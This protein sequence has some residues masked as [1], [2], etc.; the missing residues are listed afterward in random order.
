MLCWETPQFLHHVE[1]PDHVGLVLGHDLLGREGAVVFTIAKTLGVEALHLPATGHVP[2]PVTL[3]ERRTAD[4]L[5]RPV[6]NTARGELFARVLPEEGAVVHVEGQKAAQIGGGRIP[7]EPA[8]AVVCAHENPAPRHHGIAIRLAAESG[9]PGDVLARLGLPDSRVKVEFAGRPLD[10][11]IPR[12]GHVVSLG[13]A[14]PLVPVGRYGRG[15][16][17]GRRQDQGHDKGQ[18]KGRETGTAVHGRASTETVSMKIS[19]SLAF[20]KKPGLPCRLPAA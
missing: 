2:E 7:L 19:E 13:Q 5:E 16:G 17:S 10:R 12:L 3:N 9:H 14:A 1:H 20:P 11:E 8:L 6:V 4:P 18:N 15:R